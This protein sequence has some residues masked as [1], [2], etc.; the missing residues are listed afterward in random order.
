VN[1]IVADWSPAEA[2]SDV[3]ASGAAAPLCVTV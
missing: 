2:D 1:E 3:G